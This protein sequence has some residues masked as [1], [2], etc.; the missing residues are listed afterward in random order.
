MYSILVRPNAATVVVVSVLL[1]GCESFD[2]FEDFDADSDGWISGEEAAESRDLSDLFRSA[3]YNGDGV[4][5]E[6]EYAVAQKAITGVRR[7]EKRRPMG[8]ERG[9]VKRRPTG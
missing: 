3:D 7:T 4:L 5:D 2:S 1:T 9:G 8:T 6:E